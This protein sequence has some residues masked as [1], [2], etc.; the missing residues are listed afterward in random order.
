MSDKP[1]KTI[2][3]DIQPESSASSKPVPKKPAPN[4]TVEKKKPNVV[5]EAKKTQDPDEI[6]K[7]EIEVAKEEF[8]KELEKIKKHV[9]IEE[10]ETPKETN[11]ANKAAYDSMVSKR[12]GGNVTIMSAGASERFDEVKKRTPKKTSKLMADS[13]FS[14]RNGK[15]KFK[16]DK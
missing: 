7:H 4:N 15:K 9:N 6:V 10:E 11:L 14:A 1:T 12:E 8:K 13:V 3:T 5:E 16:K 2:N